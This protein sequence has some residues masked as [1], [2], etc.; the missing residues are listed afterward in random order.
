MAKASEKPAVDEDGIEITDPRHGKSM[1][2]I[3]GTPAEQIPGSGELQAAPAADSPEDIVRVNIGGMDLDLP[4]GAAEAYRQEAEEAV[5]LRSKLAAADAV[6]ADRNVAPAPLAPAGGEPTPDF[7]DGLSN[8]FFANPAEAFRD[9][10]GHISQEVST[11]LT[12]QYTQA[13]TTTRFWDQ[14]YS[15]NADLKDAKQFVE[16]TL[17]QN[18]DSLGNLTIEDSIPKL[19]ELSRNKVLDISRQVGGKPK[20]SSKATELESGTGSGG[21]PAD[22]TA[23]VPVT[24]SS[25]ILDGKRKRDEARNG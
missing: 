4:R 14:F 2:D 21:A 9:F 22:K 25:V 12:A 19:A 7:Y 8:K 6:I 24:L 15:A 1:E 20:G 3:D 5:G 17:S 11:G 18:W 13:Q 16:L 23:A 10:A